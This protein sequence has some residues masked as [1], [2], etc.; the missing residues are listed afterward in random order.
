MTNLPTI[1]AQQNSIGGYSVVSSFKH[2]WPICKKKK[3]WV[4]LV[5]VVVLHHKNVW[6]QV[7]SQWSQ[8]CC[9]PLNSENEL[10]IVCKNMVLISLLRTLLKAP[11]ERCDN[12]VIFYS[13]K[14]FVGTKT[15]LFKTKYPLCLVYPRQRYQKQ[16]TLLL[17]VYCSI[18]NKIRSFGCF[19]IL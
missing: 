8:S 5:G 12:C 17:L 10:Y 14:V 4:A 18:L 9:E 11:K 15:T 7:K 13:W 3:S 19:I 16:V 6:Q 2:Y 1:E